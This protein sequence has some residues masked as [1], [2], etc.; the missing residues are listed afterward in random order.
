MKSLSLRFA[1]LG[2]LIRGCCLQTAAADQCGTSLRSSRMVQSHRK[3]TPGKNE[4][5]EQ[6]PSN[7]GTLALNTVHTGHV[8][9]YLTSDGSGRCNFQGMKLNM[10]RSGI[11]GNNW[12]GGLACG[13][14]VRVKPSQGKEIEVYSM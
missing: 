3:A 4:E 8:T 2:I 12:N 11:G 1:L 10:L 13:S 7:V 6:A 9:N 14:C 5:G